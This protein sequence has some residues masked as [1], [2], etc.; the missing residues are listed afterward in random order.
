MPIWLFLLTQFSILA[1]ALLCGVFL[2]F[3]DFIMRA[4]ADAGGIAGIEAMQSIN[5]AVFRWMFMALFLGMVPASLIISGYSVVNLGSPATALMLLAGLIYLIGCF[6]VTIVFNVPMNEALAGMDMSADA[7]RHYW[8]RTY[9]PRWTFW[10]T[11]RTVACLAAAGFLLA[12][13]VLEM[14]NQ[15]G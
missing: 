12:G 2:A 3:S 8:T 1:Y 14:Q 15:A 7:T 6:G 9:L 10:N 4:L 11:I 5:R 13:L